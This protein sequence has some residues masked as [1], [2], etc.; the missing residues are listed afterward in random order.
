MKLYIL[1]GACSLV[2]H[3]A[4][5]W[6]KADYQLKIMEHKSLKQPDFLKLNPQGSVPTLV[7]DNFVLSQNIA[8]LTYLAKVFPEAKLL[9]SGD[10]KAKVKVM[11]WLGFINA[12][13]HKAFMPIFQPKKF[14]D[15]EKLEPKLAEQATKNLLELLKYPNEVLGKQD[16]LTTEFTLADLY[17]YVI[18]RWFD[19]LDV[20]GQQFENLSAYIKRVEANP[21]VQQAL[22]EEGLSVL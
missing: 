9:G 21:A 6:A 5:I 17:L 13:L 11:Q 19:D 15:D 1:P 14:I 3:T 12:D 7:D 16:Y 20:D 8:V 10:D 4:L 18:L 2:A 22:A